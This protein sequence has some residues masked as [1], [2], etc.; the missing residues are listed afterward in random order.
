VAHG[1]DARMEKAWLAAFTT[2]RLPAA[3][4]GG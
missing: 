2:S 4:S 1:P 3:V